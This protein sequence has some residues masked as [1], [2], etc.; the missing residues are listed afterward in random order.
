MTQ[1]ELKDLRER[2]LA[3]RRYL[4]IDNKEVKIQELEIITQNPNFWNK[5]SD[6]E[7]V[8]R[9]IKGLKRWVDKWGVVNSSIEDT[10]VLYEF[11]QEGESEETEVNK[12]FSIASR[13]L[14][15][16]EF[17]K[18]LSKEEDVLGA[19]IELN[20]GAGGTE[21]QDWVAMLLRMYSMWADKHKFKVSQVHAVTGE[22][23]GLKSV[24]IEIEGDYAFGYLK[25][26]NGVHRLVRISP[27]DSGNR[28][29]TSFAS[30]YVYPLVDD[31]IHIEVNIA[32]ITWETFRASGAGGQNVNK[33]ETAVRLIHKP[34]DIVLEC[35]E[36]RSQQKNK[37]KA[38]KLLKSRLYE[39]EIQKRNEERDVIEASKMKIEWGAQIRNYVMHP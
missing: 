13:Q 14:A 36:E 21:S 9:E 29:H 6:A 15:N 30:A 32:D 37:D 17:L 1:E 34:T 16:L 33:V 35:Q 7:E 5:A 24:T 20:S 22:E 28:R 2:I 3:L 10:E 27:F 12:S 23:T 31:S 18:M 25:G 11:F 8:L 19:V 4:D 39:M 26:E 38:I